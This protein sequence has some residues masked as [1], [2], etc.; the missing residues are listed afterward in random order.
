MISYKFERKFDFL[1]KKKEKAVQ[2]ATLKE[3][4]NCVLRIIR[5]WSLL[6]SIQD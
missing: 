1:A 3:L 5:V 2:F 6:C 4:R